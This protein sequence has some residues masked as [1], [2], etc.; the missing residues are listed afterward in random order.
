[1]NTLRKSLVIAALTLAACAGEQQETKPTPPP[2]PVAQT[3]PP[4]PPAPKPEA[5]LTP[6]QPFRAE[7]PKPLPVAPKFDAPV[8]TQRKLKN[9]LEVLVVE[10]H[11]LPLVSID[12][13]VKTGV[14]GE[15]ADKPGLAEFVASMLDEGTKSRNTIQ[16][17]EAFENVAARFSASAGLDSTRLHLNSLV[18]TLP[19]ALDV[20]SDVAL[21]PAF[22]PA[23]LERV[24]AIKLGE[25]E[26]K[27]AVP[28]PLA[29]DE[30]AKQLYGEKH[31]WG[32]PSGGT[33]KSVKSYTQA[34]L[35]KFHRTW[36]VPNNA[37][38]SVV[39]DIT[40]DD[41]VKLLETKFS[42]WKSGKLPKL[43]LPAFPKL[44][45]RHIVFVPKEGATQSQVWTG[46][47]LDAK[48]SDPQAISLKTGNYALGGLFSSRLNMN[49]REAHGYSYGVFSRVGF[50]KDGGTV[51]AQGGIIAKNTVDAVKEYANELTKF[52]DGKITDEELHA[53]QQAYIRS[54]PSILETN[55]SV[56]TALNALVIQGLPV[57]Y[58]R[59]LPE[60]VQAVTLAD[61]EK[62]VTHFIKPTEWP[63]VVAG[64]PGFEEGLKALNLGTVT[65]G[66]PEAE[67]APA[68]KS[69]G[70][71]TGATK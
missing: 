35:Q 23:D 56:A 8:P 59:T 38:V 39:G 44:A 6:D 20:F 9:G 31:P 12:L 14:D 61:V 33:P 27:L 47:R 71:G 1:M 29:Y 4:A 30:M 62:A 43:K 36:F 18:E 69:A 11:A 10:N 24:R 3:P 13:L 51:M 2:A 34:D 63:V 46:T 41:A 5:Q 19:Q 7:Q 45:E 28:G 70:G 55:D 40:A 15:P 68:K 64:P 58:Y 66:N 17:A 65:I 26:Q 25:L 32:K 37:V 42:G 21:N 52:S 53:G 60:K 48:A 16:V 54:L 67:E 57:D 50:N 22:R 49:L